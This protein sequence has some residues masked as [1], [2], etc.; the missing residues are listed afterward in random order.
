MQKITYRK[1]L[2][3]NFLLSHW[4]NSMWW[5]FMLFIWVIILH[6]CYKIDYLIMFSMTVSHCKSAYT[7]V[8][9]ICLT[10]NLITLIRAATCINE[11]GT[12]YTMNSMLSSA[13]YKYWISYQKPVHHIQLLIFTFKGM[14]CVIITGSLIHNSQ[15]N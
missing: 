5:I 7:P 9:L 10:I 4:T 1:M 3:R 14:W 12:Q 11:F 13:I 15:Y 2:I 8:K 6:S